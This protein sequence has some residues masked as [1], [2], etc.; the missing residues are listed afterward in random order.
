MNLPEDPTQT[1]AD[2]RGEFELIAKAKTI[3][4][5]DYKQHEHFVLQSI[6]NRRTLQK[7]LKN[8]GKPTFESFDYGEMV[9]EFDLY[10]LAVH[11]L[12][13][14]DILK[15]QETMVTLLHFTGLAGEVGE[16]GEKIKKSIR[17]NKPI[18]LNDISIAKELGDIEWYLTR[19]EADFGFKKDDI[20]K[21]NYEKLSR[22]M[23][24]DKLH[25][26]GD[27]REEKK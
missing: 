5:V 12:F 15:I 10:P 19:L 16:L 17:D 7:E 11:D 4:G 26:D 21:M 9:K 13:Q 8:I 1:E 24:Q 2:K 3:Y 25:G 6:M 27:N 18:G 23:D 14:N 20:L 22:R